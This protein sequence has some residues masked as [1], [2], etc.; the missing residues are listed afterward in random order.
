M[1]RGMKVPPSF[2]NA[3]GH[4]ITSMLIHSLRLCRHSGCMQNTM[5][6]RQQL[7]D[8]FGPKTLGISREEGLVAGGVRAWQINVAVFGEHENIVGYVVG[9]NNTVFII[10]FRC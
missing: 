6:H 1:L 10:G 9:L 8:L 4:L 5:H 7:R 2:Q 3:A